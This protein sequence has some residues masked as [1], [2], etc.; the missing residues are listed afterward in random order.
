[1]P[2]QSEQVHAAVAPFFLSPFQFLFKLSV[3][4]EHL[5]Y[6]RQKGLETLLVVDQFDDDLQRIRTALVSIPD[7]DTVIDLEWKTAEMII[8][9]AVNRSSSRKKLFA[10]RLTSSLVDLS[11]GNDECELAALIPAAS[12]HILVYDTDKTRKTISLLKITTLER[13]V[14]RVCPEDEVS[15]FFDGSGQLRMI[16]RITTQGYQILMPDAGTQQFIPTCSLPFDGVFIPLFISAD[17]KDD[18]YALTN[19]DREFTSLAKVSYREAFTLVWCETGVEGDV[20]GITGLDSEGH[21][22]GVIFATARHDPLLFATDARQLHTL[23]KAKTA[24]PLLRIKAMSADKRRYMVAGAGDTIPESYFL[25]DCTTEQFI[26]LGCSLPD[27]DVQCLR[28]MTSLTINS[29]DG[30]ALPCF[31][32]MPK[33]KQVCPLILFP[34]AGPWMHDSWGFNAIVQCFASAG[35]AVLQVNFRGSTGYGRS[36]IR[37]SIG[38]WGDNIQHDLTTALQRVM[39][40]FPIDKTRIFAFGTSFGGLASLLQLARKETPFAGAA[41]LN[42][43]TDLLA[44]LTDLPAL[45]LP[46]QQAFYHLIANPQQP[47][48]STRLQ[49]ASPLYLCEA[50]TA[51]ILLLHSE[52]DQVVSIEQSLKFY[53]SMSELRRECQFKVLPNEGHDVLSRVNIAC[54]VATALDFFDSVVLTT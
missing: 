33:M 45:W 3:T 12:E 51:P 43:P 1:M 16:F 50:I 42:A 5:A 27:I 22:E 34:H 40:D 6:I 36:Y 37:K 41:T 20:A 52:N 17:P 32:T 24:L 2:K 48:T 28:P 8:I 49:Q 9:V 54:A 18:F 10:Y 11:S 44:I 53:Q 14:L 21:I 25:Y 13:S 35:Y 46:L 15:Y 7:G 38:H 26:A 47:E 31:L 4:G 19:L 29:H 30:T 23:L 39:R